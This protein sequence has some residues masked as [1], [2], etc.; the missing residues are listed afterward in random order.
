MTGVMVGE[1]ARK[2]SMTALAQVGTALD[3]WMVEHTYALM[4]S[5]GSGAKM[6]KGGY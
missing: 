6:T 3:A 5:P 4:V 2:V 1:G